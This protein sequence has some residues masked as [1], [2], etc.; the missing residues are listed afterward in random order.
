[1]DYE[2]DDKAILEKLQ[3]PDRLDEDA[4]ET[5]P[6]CQRVAIDGGD[7]H[8]NGCP[9]EAIETEERYHWTREDR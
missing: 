1:M 4:P 2:A 9:E 7:Q 8:W 6:T 3:P 5:C